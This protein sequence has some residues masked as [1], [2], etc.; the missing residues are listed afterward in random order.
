VRRSLIA[1]FM[2]GVAMLA[3]AS[4]CYFLWAHMAQDSG[5]DLGRGQPGSQADHTD[6]LDAEIAPPKLP[7]TRPPPGLGINPWGPRDAFPVIRKPSYVSAAQGDALL[8]LDEPVLGL[9]IGTEAR[10]YSTNQL[11][12]HEM[13][14]DEVG[15]T[16]VLVTY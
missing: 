16:P 14:V 13:V 7:E 6:N 12:E 2:V 11:N 4:A 5:T 10:A 15:G 3:I 1:S 9:A 8:G